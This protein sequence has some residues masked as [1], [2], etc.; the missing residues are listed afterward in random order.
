MGRREILL[1]RVCGLEL[2]GGENL[3]VRRFG[4]WEGKGRHWSN[5]GRAIRQQQEEQQ[6]LLKRM[7]RNLSSPGAKGIDSTDSTVK[8]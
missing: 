6:V 4:M 3:C 5:Y 1:L 2:V 8:W 7:S